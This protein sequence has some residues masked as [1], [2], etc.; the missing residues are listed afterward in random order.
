VG[1]HFVEVEADAPANVNHWNAPE[2]NPFLYGA[3]GDGQVFGKF[4][5]RQES[6]G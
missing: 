6:R 1:K 2:P 3:L 4:A 5:C